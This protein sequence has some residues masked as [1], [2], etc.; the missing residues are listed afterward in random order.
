MSTS[1]SPTVLSIV[2][3]FQRLPSSKWHMDGRHVAQL[4]GI[5]AHHLGSFVKCIAAG[6]I[7]KRSDD[8]WIPNPAPYD[9]PIDLTSRCDNILNLHCADAGNKNVRR[10][11]SSEID[12][13]ESSPDVLNQASRF[14]QLGRIHT[15]NKT[16]TPKTQ[17]EIIKYVIGTHQTL[18]QY[19][20]D[21]AKFRQENWRNWVSGGQ[22]SGQYQ[23]AHLPFIALEFKEVWDAPVG[24]ATTKNISATVLN[25]VKNE[26]LDL[27]RCMFIIST[28]Q[29]PDITRRSARHMPTNDVPIPVT[30]P[31]KRR[32]STL[33]N[34]GGS[35]DDEDQEH[36]GRD[37]VPTV[38][39][40][41]QAAKDS[42]SLGREAGL[43]H[44]WFEGRQHR[45]IGSLEI[46]AS[47]AYAG[48]TLESTNLKISK[49]GGI[50]RTQAQFDD[51]KS[52]GKSELNGK[53]KNFQILKSSIEERLE[54]VIPSNCFCFGDGQFLLEYIK[55]GERFTK[56]QRLPRETHVINKAND[57][58]WLTDESAHYIR[59]MINC[60]HLSITKF[61]GL[62]NCMA[63]YL[64]GRQ[65]KQHEFSSTATVRL[66]LRRLAIIDRKIQ[67]LVDRETFGKSPNGFYILYFV[68]A[69]GTTHHKNIHHQ[70]LIRT[71]GNKDG[72]KEYIVLTS[73]QA[74]GKGA[75]DNAT[76]NLKVMIKNIDE[77]VLPYFGG[78]AVDNAA[79]ARDEI[80]QTFD[81]L[82]KHLKDIGSE[83]HHFYGVPRLPIVV[84]DGFNDNY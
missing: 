24:N 78:G 55:E 80:H 23:S 56:G 53:L 18:T 13:A 16:I 52:I 21:I 28:S 68:A 5:S 64:L 41:V 77:K 39:T 34:E 22:G 49:L 35:G 73:S 66:R 6:G 14:F 19:Y 84:P 74:L 63:V 75:K 20:P 17:R 40:A 15:H 4:V 50:P 70:A 69:D 37:F 9:T 26:I 58:L 79:S 7:G 3:R 1:T 65:L 60:Y 67:A 29:C 51:I 81:G 32:A 33:E 42:M 25:L 8:S 59:H 44:Q 83:L 54:D 38:I 47:E 2:E 31:K 45:E 36:A 61:N 30:A 12:I 48:G 62:L 43:R 76:L 82:M 57:Q 11:S 72:K 46:A 10:N 27:M 71:G